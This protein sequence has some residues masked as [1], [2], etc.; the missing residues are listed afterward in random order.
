MPLDVNVTECRSDPRGIM[1]VIVAQREYKQSEF[2]YEISKTIEADVLK[3]YGNI[4]LIFVV[5]KLLTFFTLWNWLKSRVTNRMIELTKKINNNEQI[6]DRGNR[7][8]EEALYRS[9]SIA[10]KDAGTALRATV[11]GKKLKPI[12]SDG[13]TD[14]SRSRIGSLRSRLSIKGEKIADAVDR[15]VFDEKNQATSLDSARSKS[16][17]VNEI[18]ELNDAMFALFR[19]QQSSS[20]KDR[21]RFKAQEQ[22]INP[23]YKDNKNSSKL[24]AGENY[25]YFQ[26]NEI[27]G[28]QEAADDEPRSR[29]SKFDLDRPSSSRLKPL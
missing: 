15:M 22:S 7:R 5:V 14:T 4:V 27:G 23:C 11:R 3:Y 12:T 13:S 2:T 9:D 19:E 24:K 18:D 6:D 8:A 16:K 29:P 25:I 10:D 20:S 26:L 21:V 28:F 17:V 1:F